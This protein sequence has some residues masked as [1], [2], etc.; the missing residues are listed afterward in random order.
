VRID[1]AVQDMVLTAKDKAVKLLTD[2]LDV[3]EA[4][5]SALLEKETIVLE[6]IEVIL[7]ELRPN[8]KP[9]AA[10]ETTAAATEPAAENNSETTA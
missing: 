7:Q 2:N 4:V 9:A 5:A 6:D 10:D 8:A 3:L 1:E